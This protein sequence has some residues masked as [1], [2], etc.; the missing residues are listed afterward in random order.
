M[1][2]MIGKE[3]SIA[4]VQHEWRLLWAVQVYAPRACRQDW[5]CLE[6]VA[7]HNSANPVA[8]APHLYRSNGAL[9]TMACG[10]HGVHLQT[11]ENQQQ[12]E[13]QREPCQFAC[14]G[15]VCCCSGQYRLYRT[16]ELSMC[17]RPGGTSEIELL[18]GQLGEFAHSKS[19]ECEM[20]LS[21]YIV[22][23]GRA[24]H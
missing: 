3:W 2:D 18:A 14:P 1:T 11:H 8:P 5:L 23:G 19:F 12:T 7:K 13:F 21:Q 6:Q 24:S 22:S 9:S 10:V 17:P 16:A 15:V 20:L 4:S